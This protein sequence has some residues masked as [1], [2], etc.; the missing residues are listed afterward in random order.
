MKMSEM[1][2]T[3][4]KEVFDALKDKWLLLDTNV[5]IDASKAI[6]EFEEFFIELKKNCHVVTTTAVAIEFLKGGKKLERNE[7]IKRIHGKGLW[8]I[9]TI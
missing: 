4:A 7:S 9:L 2:I 5:L 1:K 3:I 8:W 6:N